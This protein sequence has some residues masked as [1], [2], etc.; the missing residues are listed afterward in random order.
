MGRANKR[1]IVFFLVLAFIGPVS[2][3]FVPHLVKAQTL[4]P[5][6]PIFIMNDA[7]FATCA[8]TS[9]GDGSSSNPYIIRNWEITNLTATY[10]SGIHLRNI[11]TSYFIVRDNYVHSP[12]LVTESSGIL[13][14][15]STKGVIQNNRASGTT[16]GIWLSTSTGVTVQNN[17]A[18]GNKNGLYITSSSNS[19]IANNQASD[20]I[21]CD[22]NHPCYGVWMQSGTYNRISGNNASN[23]FDNFL[24]SGSSHNLFEQNLAASAGFYGMLT[25]FSQNN[26][27]R[28][29]TVS[30]NQFGLILMYGNNNTAT[31][32]L[33]YQNQY[34]MG[35][36]NP[37]NNTV[38]VRN[39]VIGNL[40]GIYVFN[41]SAN[42]IYDNFIQTPAPGSPVCPS[43]PQPCVGVA[44]NDD[45]TKNYWNITKTPGTNVVGG[46]FLGGNYYSD[47]YEIVTYDSNSNLQYDTGETVIA[48]PTPYNGQALSSDPKVKY[49]DADNNNHWDPGETVVYDSNGNNAYDPG[50]SV[51]YGTAP[52][53]GTALKLDPQIEYV[54]FN[55]NG[56]WDTPDNDRDGIGETP[57]RISGGAQ[58]DRLPLLGN[59]HD[60]AVTSLT[61][62]P[63]TVKTGKPVTI[64][65]SVANQGTVTETFAVTA[66]YN[67][68]LIGTKT[69]P[70]LQARS[71]A[72]IVFQWDTSGIPPGTYAV[73][74][75]ATIVLGETNTAN[76]YSPP[77]NVTILADQ[78]PTASFTFTPASPAAGQQVAFDAS[79]SQDP[80]GTVTQYS[81]TYGDGASS[82]ITGAATAH[83]FTASGS[84][85][86]T[87]T[88]T[89]DNGATNIVS[90]QVTVASNK[91]G[92]PVNLVITATGSGATLAWAAPAYNGGSAI[93]GYVVYRGT[94]PGQLSPIATLGNVLTYKDTSVEMGRTFYYKVAA[95]N[96]A[97]EGQ[98]S[99]T[100]DVLIPNTSSN[101]PFFTSNP[102]VWAAILVALAAAGA[103]L[104]VFLRSQR[105][106]RVKS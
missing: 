70:A 27:Y 75:N 105:K 64:T 53:P 69:G 88:V 29:N 12:T 2:N 76:N 51:I 4:N 23:N 79:T 5:H 39:Y 19:L 40:F 103:G 35:L 81:W 45:T 89:D 68:I 77:E 31:G 102:I 97:V 38:F 91:P 26:V 95:L 14:E 90:H 10:P 71:S 82:A 55:G 74:A 25:V 43:P 18:S 21:Q 101:T 44:A 20:P 1:T 42:Y 78:P 37:N 48:G 24:I 46:P 47:Y 17:N 106:A 7:G 16:Y 60:I 11:Q 73:R 100:S 33:V 3:L 6:Q 8:C 28:N 66:F 67:S 63:T 83:R 65:V 94:A 87:L 32:N 98:P 57:Y 50:E 9:G 56:I 36:E 49:V 92:P 54:E 80:D 85:T 96:T 84:F 58:Y 41:S 72:S 99:S 61:L 15:A 93:T 62:S 30:R 86:V 34:G 59:L 22:I 13:L 104:T 52:A